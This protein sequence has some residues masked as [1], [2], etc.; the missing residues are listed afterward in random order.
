MNECLERSK[1]YNHEHKTWCRYLLNNRLNLNNLKLVGLEIVFTCKILI[2]IHSCYAFLLTMCLVLHWNL[3][4]D[5]TLKSVRNFNY[6][7]NCEK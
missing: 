1:Y 4:L 5:K 7:G 6:Q 3:D 2:Y